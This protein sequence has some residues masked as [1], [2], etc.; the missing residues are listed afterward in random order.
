[1]KVFDGAT[2][3]STTRSAS[4]SGFS[5]IGATGAAVLIEVLLAN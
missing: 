1:V 4:E 5:S 2:N 3:V